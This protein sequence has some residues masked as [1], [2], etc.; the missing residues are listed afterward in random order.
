MVAHKSIFISVPVQVSIEKKFKVDLIPHN[1]EKYDGDVDWIAHWFYN[2]YGS[3]I[4][5][6][7]INIKGN[8]HETYPNPPHLSVSFE[9]NGYVTPMHHL[10]IDRQS[11]MIY[12]Q[13]F[14]NASGNKNKRKKSKRNK[15]KK[16]RSKRSKTSKSKRNKSKRIKK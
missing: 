13:P 3:H 4:D 7:K 6:L 15:S 9:Y 2:Y 1:G 8:E 11:G 14:P 12:L 5:D 10:S 16:S